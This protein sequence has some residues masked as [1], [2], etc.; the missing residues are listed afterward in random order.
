M[1]GSL[2]AVFR[3]THAALVGRLG[4]VLG[5]HRLDLAESAVQEAYLRALGEWKSGTPDDPAAW[6]LRVARNAA[7]DQL[8]R[9]RTFGRKEEEVAR[10]LEGGQAGDPHRGAAL[11]GELADDELA[12]MFVAC[13]PCNTMPSRVALALR[14][15]SGLDVAAIARALY[16]TDDAIEKRLVLA[17]R[18]VREAGLGF[19]VPAGAELEA[20][21]DDV[22]CVLYLLFNEAY[23]STAGPAVIDE[24]VA[25]EAVRL[26]G[27]LAEH[28]STRRPRVLAL[29]AMML[30]HSARFPARTGPGGELVLLAEQDRSLWRRDVISRGME[31]LAASA[32]GD[33]ASAYHFEAAIAAVHAT[34]PSHE[35]TSWSR[36]VELYDRLLEVSPSPS[37]ALGR[38]VA[39][40]HRDGPE[41]GLTA[42][43]ALADDARVTGLS[44]YHAA[45]AE[46]WLRVGDATAA[47]AAYVVALERARHPSERA[48]VE[49]RIASLARS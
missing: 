27:L 2:D 42:L 30:L 21:L 31:L 41:A 7:V 43:D 14:T 28:P 35:Q 15:L 34:S 11:R 48:H 38:A 47:G 29:L 36:I 3:E 44:A 20:R 8:R 37:A 49:R 17:R 25:A 39:V 46:S 26:T 13:H 33:E 4:R 12:M 18:R 16:A 23:F 40:G 9:E 24:L 6:L 1:S 22:L 5:A 19:D 10:W 32:D 45:R